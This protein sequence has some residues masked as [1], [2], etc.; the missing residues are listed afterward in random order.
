MAR[1]GGR[2]VQQVNNGKQIIPTLIF[3]DGSILV[4]G[5][6][7]SGVEEGLFLTK[8]ATKV[9][10]LEVRDRLGASQILQEKAASHP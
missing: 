7:N 8:F 6:G 4:V 10:V 3:E 9:T 1:R 5:G 2:Y